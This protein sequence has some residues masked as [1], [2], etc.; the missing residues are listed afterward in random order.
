MPTSKFNLG[1][2]SSVTLIDGF[3]GQ[4]LKLGLVVD[5]QSAQKVKP[6]TSSPLNQRPLAFHLPAGWT[7]SFS[8]DR[9][10][11]NVDKAISAFEQAYWSGSI[12]NFSTMT[13]RIIEVNGS[14][15]KFQYNQVTWHLQDAGT[16][17]QDNVVKVKI[18]GEASGRAVI[19]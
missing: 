4:K 19:S 12:V 7:F 6:V 9:S 16:W 15:S 11:A 2:D 3:T 13:Q 5:F 1:Q 14:V 17:T 8:I 18:T 10:N